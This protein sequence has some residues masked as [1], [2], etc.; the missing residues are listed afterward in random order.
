MVTMATLST[1]TWDVMYNHLQTGT[2]AISTNNIFSAYNDKIIND[3]GLPVVVIYPPT[4]SIKQLDMKGETLLAPISFMIE[5]YHKSA[6]DCKVLIDDIQNKIV[7]GYDVFAAAR[8]KRPR[9]REEWINTISYDSWNHGD[10]HR[11][12]KYTLEVNF[13]YSE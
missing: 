12:H 10:K 13:R 6:Q 1:T 11:I 5:A 4:F 3:V 2:Y 7:V 8:M 9:D